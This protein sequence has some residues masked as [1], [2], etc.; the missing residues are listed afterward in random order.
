MEIN[1]NDYRKHWQHG[2]ISHP[3][4]YLRD[5]LNDG[6]IDVDECFVLALLWDSADQYGYVQNASAA[7]I[8][9]MTCGYFSKKRKFA[10]PKNTVT[11][12]LNSLKEKR[13]IDY[14]NMQGRSGVFKIQ[15]SKFYTRD[16]VFI[17]LQKQLIEKLAEVVLP[18]CAIVIL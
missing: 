17:D 14:P 4:Y 18:A 7:M 2:Y 8:E 15:M 9:D 5:A 1:Q 12:I 6:T 10:D 11:K 16:K 3:R 13:F